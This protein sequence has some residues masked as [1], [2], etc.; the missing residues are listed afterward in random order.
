MLYMNVWY[1]AEFSENLSDAPL[2]L[3]ML[4]RD[5]V[6][7]RN[8]D[9]KAVCLS[10]VCPHRGASLAQG[11]CEHGGISCPF[12]GWRFGNDGRCEGIPSQQ[13]PE[14]E[15]PAKAKVDSYP[16]DE[17]QGLIWVFLGDEPDAAAPV[18][19]IKEWDDPA[20]RHGQFADVWAANAHWSKMTNLDHVHLA[21]VHGIDFGGE[22]PVRPPEHEVQMLDSGFRAEISG[23]KP[24]VSTSGLE[25]FRNERS[26]VVSRLAYFIPGMTLRGQVEIGGAGSG[27]FNLFYEVSTPIDEETTQMRWLFFRN[28]AMEPEHDEMH[29]KRNLRNVF[30]DKDIA[31]TIL[32][33]RAP[34]IRGWPPIKVDREDRIMKAYWELLDDMR[35]RGWQIDRVRLDECDRDGDY[36]VIPSPARRRDPGHWVFASVPVIAATDQAKLGV[37]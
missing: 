28:F 17:R 25:E 6:L 5:F 14:H 13:K 11:K 2:H 12:H 30:Q 20:W 27:T 15:I 3:K 31:E 34:D 22:N 8:A 29:V 24:P 37:A 9:G 36:R 1:V 33:K 16:T 26:P 10:N 32:P 7:F 19:D 35:A 18:F 23:H 21:V 4:G